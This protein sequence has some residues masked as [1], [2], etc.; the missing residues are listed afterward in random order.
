MSVGEGSTGTPEKSTP[1]TLVYQ[2]SHCSG[3]LQVA[4]VLGTPSGDREG[5]H[6]ATASRYPLLRKAWKPIECLF[7]NPPCQKNHKSLQSARSPIE[8]RVAETGL[9]VM[10]S[11]PE[12]CETRRCG[13]HTAADPRSSVVP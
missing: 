3:I 10:S 9:A 11:P 12:S 13:N 6:R 7:Q 5:G 2:H 8:R 1:P 4:I